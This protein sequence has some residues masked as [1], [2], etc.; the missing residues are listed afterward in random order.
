[1]ARAAAIDFGTAAERNAKLRFISFNLDNCEI[2]IK[3]LEM[4]LKFAP[5]QQF[6]VQKVEE[7]FQLVPRDHCHTVWEIILHIVGDPLA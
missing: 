4:S 7:I 1:M 5:F 6:N 3:A 2:E